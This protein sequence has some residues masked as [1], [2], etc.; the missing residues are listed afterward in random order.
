MPISSVHASV[1]ENQVGRKV[2]ESFEKPF[3]TAFSDS[4]PVTRGG[5]RVFLERARGRREQKH[6]TIEGARYF[7][8][9]DKPDEIVAL[10]DQFIR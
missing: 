5:A 6:V 8:Q 10:L 2:L 4:D 7:L 9:E 3:L 1:E